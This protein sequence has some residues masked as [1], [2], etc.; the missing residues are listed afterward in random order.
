M[1][2]LPQTLHGQ[3]LTELWE[4]NNKEKNPG[5]L[6]PQ[7]IHV[8]GFSQGSLNLR[9]RDLRHFRRKKGVKAER[10]EEAHL[11]I[12][13]TKDQ[14]LYIWGSDFQSDLQRSREEQGFP[15][16]EIPFEI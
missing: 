14:S 10:N 2:S 6:A 4:G 7:P 3:E 13:G 8:C 16:F 5:P 1:F 11:V 9:Q 15:G 12:K